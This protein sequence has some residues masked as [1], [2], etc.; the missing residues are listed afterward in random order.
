MECVKAY[1]SWVSQATEIE[2]LLDSNQMSCKNKHAREVLERVV[3]IV[4]RLGKRP[5]SC[6]GNKSEAS[7]SLEGH[8]DRSQEHFGN[9][10]ASQ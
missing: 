5:F 3:N 9:T 10:F 2:T 8:V 1:F 4:K 7:Y 6:L